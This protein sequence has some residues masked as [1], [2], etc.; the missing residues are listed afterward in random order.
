MLFDAVTGTCV[1]TLFSTRLVCLVSSFYLELPRIPRILNQWY[2][3]VQ[4]KEYVGKK[5]RFMNDIYP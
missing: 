4:K 1:V 3:E 2:A 5:T